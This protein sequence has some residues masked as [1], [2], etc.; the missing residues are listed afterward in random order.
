MS[1]HLLICLLLASSFTAWAAPRRKTYPMN[2]SARGAQT[3]V[4]DVEEGDFVL[5]GDPAATEVRMNV[6]IDRT[7]IFKLGEEGILKRLIKISGEGTPE[8]TIRTDIPRAISNWGRAQYPIDFEVVVPADTLLILRD[9]SGVIEVSG[10]GRGVEIN[11]GSGTLTVRGIGG[12]LQ[13][14]KESGD[15]VIEEVAGKSTIESRSGQMK[16]RR[17]G[18]VSVA[19]SDGNIDLAQAASAGIHNR[20][21]NLN[22]A[23]VRGDLEIDDDSGEIVV[24]DVGGRVVL[25]DQS[26][27]IRVTRAGQVE[28]SDTSGDVTVANAAGLRVLSKESGEV[29]VRNI[30][31]AVEVAAG[32]KLKQE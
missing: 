31:G 12:P 20:G 2:V 29:K 3:I 6:S 24:T 11:D 25:R 16:L 26:G 17:L 30:G 9:T 21:G 23:H 15:V 10:M 18:E 8:L 4:F 27:Q 14:R 1:R 22:V 28:I 32:V 7:W 19:G 5:R 13:V